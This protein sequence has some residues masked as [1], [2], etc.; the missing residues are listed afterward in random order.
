MKTIC[1]Y[2]KQEFPDTPDEYLG[3]T[4]ECPVCKKE[5][6]C[7]KAKYCAECGAI[8]PARA[9]TCH[10]CGKSFPV[11][12]QP[13][14]T[15]PIQNSDSEDYTHHPSYS[16]VRISSA[17]NL[18]FWDKAGIN[19]CIIC[20]FFISL[21]CL[22]PLF[23]GKIIWAVCLLPAG[24]ICG[25]GAYLLY[26]VQNP[27]KKIYWTPY[28]KFVLTASCLIFILLGI[29][30]CVN[31]VISK[32]LKELLITLPITLCGIFGSILGWRLFNT[33]AEEDI[34]YEESEEDI[35][36]ERLNVFRSLANGFGLGALFPSFGIPFL[37]LS[38][39][40]IVLYKRKGGTDY[41]K[42]VILCVLSIV[43]QAVTFYSSRNFLL[44][45]F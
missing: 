6:V 3:V 28:R 1:P 24:I 41:W 21:F 26:A 15:P 5:F 31:A 36:S 16:T 38:G 32:E 8:N 18:S 13:P 40:F 25:H 20:G 27:N 2:C 17:D 11:V 37:V 14:V 34:D 35:A 4:L 7:E 44:R 10:Q 43:I 45:I 42:A 19:W 22:L 9:I 39:I 33:R 23:V 30:I 29:G 12:P